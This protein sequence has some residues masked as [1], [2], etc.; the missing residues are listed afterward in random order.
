MFG[1]GK[2]CPVENTGKL[3]VFSQPGFLFIS[4]VKDN[5]QEP[6]QLFK[7][8]PPTANSAIL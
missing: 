5:L 8:T 6:F 7:K 4:S 2:F 1:V 3:F